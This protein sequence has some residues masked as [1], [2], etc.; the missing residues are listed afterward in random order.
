MA[1]Q[2]RSGFTLVEL[3][4]VI[5]IIAMLVGLL[6][7][8]VSGARER[9]RQAECVNNQRQIGQAFANYETAKEHLPGYV[10]RY[11]QIRPGSA[12]NNRALSWAI[13]ILPYLDYEELWS[14]WR[15]PNV[16]MAEK[17]NPNSQHYAVVDVPQFKCPSDTETGDAGLSY[18]VNCGI[19]DGT[20]SER[21]AFDSSAAATDPQWKPPAT[22]PVATDG[23]DHGVFMNCYSPPIGGPV[24]CMSENIADGRHNTLLLSENIQAGYWHDVDERYLGIMW[25]G[26]R[27]YPDGTGTRWYW[28]RIPSGINVDRDVDSRPVPANA[29]Y[30]RPSS[31]HRGGVVAT[32]CDAHTDFIADDIGYNVFISMM[33]TDNESAKGP[34]DASE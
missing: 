16:R 32:F 11:G 6:L 24:H 8:A 7:P 25:Q 34:P 12:T 22:P 23:P 29:A 10:N 5:V 18:V 31:N 9:A 33:T 19:R 26:D 20:Q 3:L 4:V 30:A 2:H 1:N 21:L 27:S 14:R 28:N 13:V 17:L 15:D